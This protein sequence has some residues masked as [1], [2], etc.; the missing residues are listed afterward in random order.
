MCIDNQFPEQ[1][2]SRKGPVEKPVRSPDVKPL[3]FFFA[4]EVDTTK[5]ESLVQS[6]ND[7]GVSA[8]NCDSFVEYAGSIRIETLPLEVNG[9][10]LF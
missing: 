2:E 6:T 7:F 9:A 1:W 5:S 10:V 3:V 4:L 8:D